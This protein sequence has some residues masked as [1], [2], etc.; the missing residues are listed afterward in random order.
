MSDGP[1]QGVSVGTAAQ[2]RQ[3]PARRGRLLEEGVLR[4]RVR[5]GAG[6]RGSSRELQLWEAETRSNVEHQQGNGGRG[7]SGAGGPRHKAARRARRWRSGNK[8]GGTGTRDGRRRGQA[9]AGKGQRRGWFRGYRV[10]FGGGGGEGGWTGTGEKKRPKEAA[11]PHQPT[12][13][14]PDR[15]RTGNVLARCLVKVQQQH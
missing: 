8:L 1:R 10:I 7:S 14:G 11:V 4:W 5:A 12:I 3:D 15:R 2:G 6:R 13:Q 9:K